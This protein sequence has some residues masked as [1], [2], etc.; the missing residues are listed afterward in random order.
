MCKNKFQNVHIAMGIIEKY[1]THSEE[2]KNRCRMLTDAGGC[3]RMN[4]NFAGQKEQG[5]II[6]SYEI[7]WL[8]VR[9]QSAG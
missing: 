8:E 4:R 5:N 1:I 6:Q 7:V 3:G 2:I 9:S